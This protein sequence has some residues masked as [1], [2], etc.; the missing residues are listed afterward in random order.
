VP[1]FQRPDSFARFAVK[2]SGNPEALVNPVRERM[3]RIEPQ[4]PIADVATFEEVLAR[5]E[6][7]HRF[8]T[9]LFGLFA[10]LALTLAV[11]GLFG[12]L[13]YGVAQRTQ[14]CGVRLALGAQGRDILRLVLGQGLR[15]VAAGLLVG[16]G[17]AVLATR[18]MRGL[19]YGVEP[20]DA[21]TFGL[22]AA[23]LFVVSLAATCLPAL[24]ATRVDPVRALRAE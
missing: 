18:A 5:V 7:Q 4:A 22:V 16:V 3:A 2:T 20:T 17:V 1:F 9:I 13:A 6:W 12:V 21:A 15:L 8:Y 11:I 24:R 14:E 10:G 23:I 19:L